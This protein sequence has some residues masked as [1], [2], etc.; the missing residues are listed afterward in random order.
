MT[1]THSP[2]T[3]SM[4][5]SKIKP[6]EPR[7]VLFCWSTGK[8]DKM[9]RLWSTV[10]TEISGNHWGFQIKIQ[11]PLKIQQTLK[12]SYSLLLAVGMADFFFFCFPVISCPSDTPSYSYPSHLT[13]QEQEMGRA[14]S[15]ETCNT[16]RAGP[17]QLESNHEENISPSEG[18]CICR[19]TPCTFIGNW[20][21]LTAIT[22]PW[23]TGKQSAQ[24]LK[25]YKE[26]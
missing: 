23:D 1:H 24:N 22:K 3:C 8:D 5:I 6:R 25:H 2:P 17:E 21:Q 13:Q 10:M 7:D 9:G 16:H 26:S 14:S 4:H 11:I 19:K 18:N 15:W 12:M 20:V